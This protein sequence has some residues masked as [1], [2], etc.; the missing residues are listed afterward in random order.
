MPFQFPDP[1]V[2]T[3]ATLPN[4]ELWEYVNGAWRAV[5]T[6]DDDQAQIDALVAEDIKQDV[7]ISALQS[8]E[9]VD[10]HIVTTLSG[11]VSTNEDDIAA[12]QNLDVQSAISLLQTAR[13]DIIEL[14][15]KV[16]TL[17]LTQFLILE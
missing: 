2:S 17:E 6:Q 1:S 5:P 12:L 10:R 14:Q 7:E 3:T 4:G 13:Q 16:N 8:G 9:S 11:R 15:S